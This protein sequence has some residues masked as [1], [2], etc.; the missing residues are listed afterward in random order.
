MIPDLCY[1]ADDRSD[2]NI[3]VNRRDIS[4]IVVC[5]QEGD[6]HHVLIMWPIPG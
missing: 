5:K 3:P 6:I 4:F 2:L 1:D